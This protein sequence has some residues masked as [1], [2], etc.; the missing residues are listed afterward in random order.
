MLRETRDQVSL[1]TIGDRCH[2]WVASAAVSH[3]LRVG[4]RRRMANPAINVIAFTLS[5]FERST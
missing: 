3:G 4:Q 1:K 5:D 2:S